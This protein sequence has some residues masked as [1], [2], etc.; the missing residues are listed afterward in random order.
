MFV[1]F[2]FSEF[3]NHFLQL[4]AVV[5]HPL[6]EMKESDEKDAF[7][8]YRALIKSVLGIPCGKGWKKSVKNG[9]EKIVVE[10]EDEERDASPSG[11]D[12]AEE[13]EAVTSKV[14]FLG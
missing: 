7:A 14:W 5:L 12:E 9:K 6:N 8:V 13:E 3:L 1:F 11:D 2:D 10:D 4:I